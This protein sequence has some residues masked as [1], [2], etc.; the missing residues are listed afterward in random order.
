MSR[1]IEPSLEQPS[2][3]RS[4]SRSLEEGRRSPPSGAE[5]GHAMEQKRPAPEQDTVRSVRR[6]KPLAQDRPCRISPAEQ[7]TLAEIGR[8]RTL[9]R[10]DLARIDTRAIKLE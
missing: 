6:R 9:A 10:E 4:E 8:F 1:D 3:D 2:R 7:D 5:P